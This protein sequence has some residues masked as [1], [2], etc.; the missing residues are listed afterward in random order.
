MLSFRISKDDHE[1][2]SD[3]ADRAMGLARQAKLDVRKMDI[4]MDL[5]AVHANGCRMDFAAL[6]TADQ[7]NMAH[8]VFGI[9]RHLNRQTG[10]LEG[11]FVP[12]FSQRKES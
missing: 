10:Q 9:M 4:I 2:V 6:A 12:R 5:T 11:F 3:I 1:L 7:F 8:D